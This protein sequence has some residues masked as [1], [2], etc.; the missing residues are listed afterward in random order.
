M[1][2]ELATLFA[3]LAS[4]LTLG[5]LV[6]LWLMLRQAEARLAAKVAE[7]DEVT[8]RASEANNSLAAKSLQIEERLANLEFRTQAL[9]SASPVATWN[10]KSST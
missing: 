8:R 9:V 6:P 10:K 2:T 5:A 3:T 4:G 7:F 1:L